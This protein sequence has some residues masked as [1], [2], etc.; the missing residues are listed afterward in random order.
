MLPI[1]TRKKKNKES[2]FTLIEISIAIIVIGLLITPLFTL[3]DTYITEKRLR[4][5]NDTIQTVSTSLELFRDLNG[6]YPCPAPMDSTPNDTVR[7]NGRA[8]PCD[9]AVFTAAS[10]DPGDC[11]DG[12]CLKSSDRTDITASDI[13]MGTIPF[14][15]IQMTEAES[16]DGYGNRL[17]YAVTQDLT[18]ITTFD[19]TRGGISIVD[20]SGNLLTEK[21]DSMYLVLSYGASKQGA[22]N[23]N[24][25]IQQPCPTTGIEIDNCVN[26]FTNSTLTNPDAIFTFAPTSTANSNNEFDHVMTF[27]ASR[28]QAL[29]RRYD[30][31]IENAQDLSPDH[32]IGLGVDNPTAELH[33]DTPGS[34]S[35][36]IGAL[37]V[38]D[39]NAAIIVDKVCD[40]TGTYCFEPKM[41]G[42]DPDAMPATGGVRCPTGEY[43]KGIE[44]GTFECSPHKIECPNATPVF[45]GLDSAG[46]AK[47]TA[48]PGVSCAATSKTLCNANDISLPE[49][50]DGNTESY[51]LGS[52]ATASYRCDAGTWTTLSSQGGTR[53]TFVAPGPTPISGQEN[54][55]CGGSGQFGSSTYTRYSEP[56]CTGGI[57]YTSNCDAQC[58]C[59]FDNGVPLP[60]TY[61]GS[62][63]AARNAGMEFIT[64]NS[65]HV[66]P[67]NG[68]TYEVI[69][70]CNYVETGTTC[71]GSNSNGSG[72]CGLDCDAWNMSNCT[73]SG[74]DGDVQ[75]EDYKACANYNED[76]RNY[77]EFYTGR[78]RKKNVYNGAT[79]A[80]EF[81]S[82]NY[83]ECACGSSNPPTSTETGNCSDIGP[84]DTGTYTDSLVFNAGT[85]QYDLDNRDMGMCSCNATPVIF[86]EPHACADNTCEYFDGSDPDQVTVDIDASTC[87]AFSPYTIGTNATLTYTG[88][89]KE[90]KYIWK[91]ADDL[92]TNAGS[93]PDGITAGVDPCECAQA[94]DSIMCYADGDMTYRQYRCVCSLHS[95]G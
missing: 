60:P 73:C 61:Q 34:S 9:A 54:I 4:D 30:S 71:S 84:Y 67:N 22:Y 35:N 47:C 16:L 23:R 83:D 48:I 65:L 66:D 58:E 69:R 42:G 85:C 59:G 29:W 55:S 1:V 86:D 12:I 75:F 20:A 52:C 28:E 74:T 6:F 45:R 78:V 27:S 18:D 56:T 21:K 57:N 36:N 89:C 2:G 14:R 46:R 43:L 94:G 40:E 68:N 32:K 33:I 93:D 50:S 11:V 10:Q 7:V 92:G 3:Y 19:S 24:A 95:G 5:T 63:C 8:Q 49:L 87:A 79:C 88:S 44:G 64:G 90:K 72:S 13:V 81:D 26:D 62:T 76:G 70:E 53:C 38:D 25:V 37:M 80:Y 17:L 77:N 31:N 51:S 39:P 91:T 15:D 41:F 82:Y